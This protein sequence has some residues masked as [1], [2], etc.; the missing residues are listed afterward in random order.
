MKDISVADERDRITLGKKIT[1]RYGKR[2]IVID[3]VGEVVLR[4]VPKDPV[5]GFAEMGRRAG[6]N[7]YS[8]KQLKKM[9]EEEAEKEAISNIR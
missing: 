5:K 3:A 7:K 1:K 6:I 2:F 8:M 9:A 4:P